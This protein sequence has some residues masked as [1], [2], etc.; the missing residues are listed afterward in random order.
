LTFWEATP[1]VSTGAKRQLEHNDLWQIRQDMRSEVNYKLFS[2]NWKKET[3]LP[4]EQYEMPLPLI[5]V[6]YNS[7]QIL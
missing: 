3:K 5:C 2:K 6:Y 7:I 4:K 1:I